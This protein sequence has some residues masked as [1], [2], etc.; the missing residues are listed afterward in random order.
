MKFHLLLHMKVSCLLSQALLCVRLIRVKERFFC[1]LQNLTH[2]FR[3]RS[4]ECTGGYQHK[5]P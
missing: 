3:M 2:G 1:S 4:K 5:Q